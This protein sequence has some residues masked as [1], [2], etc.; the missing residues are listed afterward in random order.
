MM[1]ISAVL[2]YYFVEIISILPHAL[3]TYA[4]YN[5]NNNNNNNNNNNDNDIYLFNVEN[6]QWRCE[7]KE[8]C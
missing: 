2:L 6:I 4:F 7:P 3:F 5:T 8:K 1:N